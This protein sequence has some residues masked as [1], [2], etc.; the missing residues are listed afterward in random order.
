MTL[1]RGAFHYDFEFLAKT[2]NALTDELDW[3][4]PASLLSFHSEV[5]ALF[6]ACLM[7]KLNQVAPVGHRAELS[8]R[9]ELLNEAFFNGLPKL[10]GAAPSTFDAEQLLLCGGERIF[11]PEKARLRIW[12]KPKSFLDVFD[13]LRRRCGGRIPKLDGFFLLRRRD[14]LLRNEQILATKMFER[15]MAMQAL[16]EESG[17]G[18]FGASVNLSAGVHQRLMGGEASFEEEIPAASF[19]R[20]TACEKKKQ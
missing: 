17:E 7:N 3:V 10:V 13:L 19:A 15:G 20:K 11:L 14:G 4:L 12:S 18:A 6:G 5:H 1:S 2:I 8:A 16:G 9:S